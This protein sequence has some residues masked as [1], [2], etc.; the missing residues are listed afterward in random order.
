[1]EKYGGGSGERGAELCGECGLWKGLDGGG[2]TPKCMFID[3]CIM[4]IIA[5]WF[6]FQIMMKT[7]TVE[8]YKF[9]VM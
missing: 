3:V 5:R 7:N 1:M 2:G 8:S 9:D 6:L 4:Q